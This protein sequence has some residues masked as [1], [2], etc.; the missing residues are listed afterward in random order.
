MPV[1]L[2]NVLGNML[3][4]PNDIMILGVALLFHGTYQLFVKAFR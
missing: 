1:E 2:Q 3:R 4:H